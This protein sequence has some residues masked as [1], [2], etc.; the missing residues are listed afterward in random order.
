[1]EVFVFLQ[2]HR[3]GA[4]RDYVVLVIASDFA[5]KNKAVRDAAE[6]VEGFTC[7]RGGRLEL[8]LVNVNPNFVV[9]VHSSRASPPKPLFESP[10][11]NILFLRP[12]TCQ[13][14][15]YINMFV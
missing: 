7:S 1:V 11:A 8:S 2:V 5:I 13:S 3:L 6:F 12:G 14:V 10:S 4:V 9:A 15:S